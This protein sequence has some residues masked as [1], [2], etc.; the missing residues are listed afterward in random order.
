MGSGPYSAV[1]LR[2]IHRVLTTLVHTNVD[3]SDVGKYLLVKVDYTGYNEFGRPDP[4][5]GCDRDFGLPGTG[6]RAKRRQQF[7]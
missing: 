5:E 3:E 1:A 7:T 2:T 6:G 4:G